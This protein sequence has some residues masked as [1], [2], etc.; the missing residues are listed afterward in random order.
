MSVNDFS[1]NHSLNSTANLCFQ[2]V[3]ICYPLLSLLTEPLVIVGGN[4]NAIRHP[5][6]HIRHDRCEEH[7]NFETRRGVVNIALKHERVL[8]LQ[9][10]NPPKTSLCRTRAHRFLYSHHRSMI[11]MVLQCENV[12]VTIEMLSVCGHPTPSATSFAPH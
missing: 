12:K 8:C 7:L 10:I 11:K 6:T 3:L 5:H 1:Q 4:Y 2:H 9:E